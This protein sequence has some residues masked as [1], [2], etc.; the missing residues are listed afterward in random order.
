MIITIS[1]KQGAGKTTLAKMLS[2]KLNFE[3]ISI[4]DLRGQIATERGLTI[5][6]LN[7]IGKKERWVH[8]EADKKTIEIGKTKDNFIVEGWAAWHFIPQSKKIFLEVDKETGTKRIFENQRFDEKPCKDIK[9]M[10]DLLD[11]R[12]NETAKAF[13]KYYHINFL[14]HDNYDFVLDTTNLTPKETLKK[15]LQLLKNGT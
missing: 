6:E 3:F 12:L 1:G 9:E 13:K 8:E 15:T 14:D 10:R 5:D 4:G 2:K 11:L 7:E